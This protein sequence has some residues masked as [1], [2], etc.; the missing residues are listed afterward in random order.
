M[1]ASF[2]LLSATAKSRIP[3]PLKS[4]TAIEVGAFPTEMGEKG[5]LTKETLGGQAAF[6]AASSIRIMANVAFACFIVPS[7]NR[8]LAPTGLGAA[9]AGD[10]QS[11]RTSAIMIAAAVAS[12]MF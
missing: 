2:M 5:A 9:F 12:T 3:S 6:A 1:P 8:Q 7:L 11:S 4:P 10:R